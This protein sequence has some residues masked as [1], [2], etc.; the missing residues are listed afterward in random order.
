MQKC[1]GFI[2]KKKI[3]SSLTVENLYV[4]NIIV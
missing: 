2:K 1:L 3:P 4:E